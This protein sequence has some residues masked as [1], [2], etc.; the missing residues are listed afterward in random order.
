[1]RLPGCCSATPLP[2]SSS[3]NTRCD[4]AKAGVRCKVPWQD[5]RAYPSLHTY[6]DTTC[7]AGSRRGRGRWG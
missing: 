1:M 7:E 2:T 6:L 5:I 4:I 3:T